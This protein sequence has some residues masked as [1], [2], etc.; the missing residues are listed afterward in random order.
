MLGGSTIAKTFTFAAPDPDKPSR[1][2][3]VSSDNTLHSLT[4]YATST[5][6][7]LSAIGEPHD[8]TD[9][10]WL[11]RWR[12]FVLVL[13]GSSTLTIC[14]QGGRPML[15]AACNT[16]VVLGSYA[17]QDPVVR[18]DWIYYRLDDTLIRCDIN[19][20]V[21]VY[22]GGM[23]VNTKH[24]LARPVTAFMIGGKGNKFIIAYN[25][26]G[27]DIRKY[28][29][30]GIF[31]RRLDL[32]GLVYIYRFAVDTSRLVI[33]SHQSAKQNEV[34]YIERFDL[35]NLDFEKLHELS[36]YSK[37]PVTSCSL[38]SAVIFRSEAV[39]NRLLLTMND[40]GT[41]TILIVK[42]RKLQVVV[43]HF[44]TSMIKAGVVS[45]L[46]L[47]KMWASCADMINKK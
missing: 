30:D 20:I 8:Y 3:A 2:L 7:P 18:G 25:K 17:V 19:K 13:W 4:P 14:Q 40:K 23:A 34:G 43:D 35:Y 28:T 12:S 27:K 22:G 39:R 10:S 36:V 38:T 29:L 24:V 32:S 21:D 47:M 41:V 46:L 37:L 1:L 44:R 42:N 9:A 5:T 6:R 33:T 31:L 16:V 15:I 45:G 26:S 11:R